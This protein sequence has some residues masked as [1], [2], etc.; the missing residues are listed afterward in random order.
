M[1][2]IIDKLKNFVQRAV[3]LEGTT[4]FF[5]VG[6]MRKDKT[7]ILRSS[8]I[9]EWLGGKVE[10]YHFENIE[11]K[12]LIWEIEAMKPHVNRI[13]VYNNGKVKK[14]DILWR[15]LEWN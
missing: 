10:W 7:A 4:A 13:I 14:D 3:G 6:N 1:K 2:N 9:I 8:K 11:F 12:D 15:L 5:Q